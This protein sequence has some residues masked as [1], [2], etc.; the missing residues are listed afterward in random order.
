MTFAESNLLLKTRIYNESP[1]GIKL[2]A[3][4]ATGLHY[5]SRLKILSEKY[6]EISQKKNQ[7]PIFSIKKKKKGEKT[8]SVPRECDE[9]KRKRKVHKYLH[10]SLLCLLKNK[11]NL[12]RLRAKHCLQKVTCAGRPGAEE[13]KI[14]TSP[15]TKCVQPPHKHQRTVQKAAAGFALSPASSPPFTRSFF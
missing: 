4:T 11:N 14:K 5:R 9:N 8:F 1:G 15:R 10:F 13:R 7:C 6:M 3:R 12:T 2:L